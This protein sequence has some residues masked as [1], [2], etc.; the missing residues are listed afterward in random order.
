MT[1]VYI[2]IS[3]LSVISYI[4]RQY[5]IF[6]L[7][8]TSLM[9]D[10]FL[11]DSI[12]TSIKGTD[13][14]FLLNFLLLP[15]ALLRRYNEKVDDKKVNNVVRIFLLFII[16][17]SICTIG[18]GAETLLYSFKVVRVPLM[19][20]GY[21]AF[22]LIPLDTYKQYLKIMLYITIIQS[23]LFLLQFI[24]V[25]ILAG[26][27]ESENFEFS[28]AL[29][30][31]TF[32]YLYIFFV[33][34]SEYVKKYKYVLLMLFI[35]VLLLTFV[36]AILLSTVLCLF[37]YIV[38]HR[39]IRRSVYLVFIFL[40]ILPITLSVVDKKQEANGTHSST[41]EEIRLLFSGIDNIRELGATSGSLIFRM[42]MLVER[43]D[44]LI[45]NPK[46]LMLGVGTIHEDSPNC[47]NRFDFK[48][49]TRNEDKY[50][51][52]CLIDSGDITWV[53]IVLR[54]GL[55]GTLLHLFVLFFIIV[56]AKKRDDLLKI[57]CPL[58]LLFF[59]KSFDGPFFERPSTYIEIIIYYVL[60]SR[61]YLER[62][63]LNI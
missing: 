1:F 27:V 53:P 48:L 49:G 24:G 46:F 37:I 40:V 15:V 50:F 12:G 47:Y 10:L 63:K 16:I 57:L 30:I 45:E 32:I 61:T 8:Y 23:I 59:I 56:Q 5:K 36:R 58:F 18:S 35:M 7:C 38:F 60:F 43:V 55:L 3:L 42:S 9:T 34:E 29:N 2:L 13:L 4:G 62:K 22:S 44:Y 19:M 11:L 31:P 33:L 14:C 54:Y 39:G 6:L 20:V 51:G 41:T 25:D 21:Y 26:G 17:E 52:K 28:Y